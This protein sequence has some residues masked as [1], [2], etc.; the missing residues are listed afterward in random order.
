MSQLISGHDGQQYK[1]SFRSKEGVVLRG[2]LIFKNVGNTDLHV[3]N[4]AFD[5][6][7]CYSRGIEVISCNPFTIAPFDNTA[8]INESVYLLEIRYRP[9]FTMATIRKRLVLETNIGLLRYLIEIQIPHNMLSICHDSLP[10]PPLESHLF[11]LGFFLVVLLIIVMLL[12]SLVE[13]RSIIKYQYEVYKQLYALN[14]PTK[15]WLSGSE[16]DDYGEEVNV[17]RTNRNG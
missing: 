7:S 16:A 2:H 13:S 12:T 11:Y 9:D 3:L 8:P 5:G 17:N 14:D 10:R 4:V 1:S 6:E 15:S